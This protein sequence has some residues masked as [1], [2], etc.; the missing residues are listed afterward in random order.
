MK[1]KIYL[2]LFLLSLS[3]YLS[4]Q[5]SSMK[6]WESLLNKQELAEYFSGTFERLG[7]LVDSTNE[8]FTVVHQRNHFTL[9]EGVDVENVDY[10]IPLKPENVRNLQKHVSDS[11]IDDQESFKIMSVLFTPL[12]Q[13]GLNHP[14]LTN[15]KMLRRIKVEQHLHVYLYSVDKTQNTS[16][17]IIFV[18][19]Q[20]LLIPGIQGKAQRVLEM[21]P[22]DAIEYQKELFIAQKA[23]SKEGWKAFRKWFKAW[24]ETVTVTGNG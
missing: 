2:F 9:E 20:W 12:T 7:I 13:S 10:V 17:T 4:A 19:K 16:H 24:Q 1:P 6:A 8:A 15:A 21:Q 22:K 14:Y 11:K 3:T 5:S 23:N 18:N